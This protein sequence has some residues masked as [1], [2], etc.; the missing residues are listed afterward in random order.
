MLFIPTKIGKGNSYPNILLKDLDQKKSFVSF[1][2]QIELYL[3]LILSFSRQIW[4]YESEK[5]E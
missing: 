1:S 4:S 2:C 5:A 3:D